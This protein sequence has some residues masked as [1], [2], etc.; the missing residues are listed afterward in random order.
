MITF[1]LP[2]LMII[3]IGDI[4]L[5]HV[6]FKFPESSVL[7]PSKNYSI[8]QDKS[9]IKIELESFN[10]S[11]ERIKATECRRRIW[12]TNLNLPRTVD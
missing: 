6:H 4:S 5:H 12:T 1:F 10:P 2:S 9:A 7:R 3:V 11:R 8:I